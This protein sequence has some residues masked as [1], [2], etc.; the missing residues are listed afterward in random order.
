MDCPK[1]ISH[2][3]KKV[4]TQ[5]GVIVDYCPLC[6][7]IWLDQGEIYFFTKSPKVMHKALKDGLISAH[8]GDRKC[9]CCPENTKMIEGGLISPALLVDQCP[10][11]HGIWFDN[12]ELKEAM[13]LGSKNTR[14]EME[15]A[16]DKHGIFYAEKDES[17]E[18]RWEEAKAAHLKKQRLSA[19]RAGIASLPSLTMRSCVSFVLLYGFLAFMLLLIGHF[20]QWSLNFTVFLSIGIVFIQYLLSPF[21]LDLSLSW[22]Y[23]MEWVELSKLPEHLS[24]FLVRVCKENKIRVPRIGI[25]EDSNPNAFTYGHTPGNARIV[26]SRGILEYLDAD[27]VEAVVAHE[28]G[29]AC[30]WDILVM[31][32]ASIVPILLYYLY[33]VLIECTRGRGDGRA[34]LGAVVLSMLSYVLYIISEYIVLWLSRTREYWADRFAGDVTQ[35]PNSLASA[36]VKIAYGLVNPKN[37]KKEENTEGKESDT[38]DNME[39]LKALSIFDRKAAC[40]LAVNAYSCMKYKD[41]EHKEEI[42]SA[43]QWDLWNPWASYYEIH[44]TH[45]LPAKRI[46]ALTDHA[47]T[48]NQ[49]PYIIFNRRKPESYWDDFLVDVFFYLLPMGCILG[50]CS[51]IAYHA[52]HNSLRRQNGWRMTAF[53]LL[54]YGVAYLFQVLFSYRGKIFPDMKISSLL[55]KV[56]VSQIRPIPATITG[57]VIGRGVPG[58]LLSEDI[59]IEDSTGILFLDYRQPLSIIEFFFALMKTEKFI[60]KKIT[61]EGWYRRAPMPYLEIKTLYVDGQVHQCYVYLF[62]LIFA[63]ILFTSSIFCFY[64]AGMI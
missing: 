63:A 57:K 53:F 22:M 27:E 34:K 29:H 15:V 37:K 48:L 10:T 24:Q 2:P 33:R 20:L 17:N 18:A 47:A 5:Q 62:K 25:I 54:I 32:L 55:S 56:K 35:K 8:Q 23:K 1:C 38:S 59:V 7:G 26:I 3:L 12:G 64:K 50:F 21:I 6:K 11:C 16:R 42:A 4:H 61:A 39:A 36:L 49:E 51:Y 31:T 30:H 14:I 40:A 41:T 58:Y 13:D 44:S 9:P 28:L 60:G 46:N 45:P 43:M 52:I 19:L